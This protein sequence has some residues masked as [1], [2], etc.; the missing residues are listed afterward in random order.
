MRP[1]HPLVAYLLLRLLLVLLYLLPQLLIRGASGSL[2][3]PSVAPGDVVFPVGNMPRLFFRA[4]RYLCSH[5][6]MPGSVW[7]G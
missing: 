2:A 1:P 3:T 5:A 6:W 4:A 7:P